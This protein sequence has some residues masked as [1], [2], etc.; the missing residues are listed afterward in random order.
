MMI[1]TL[2]DIAQFFWLSRVKKF[3]NLSILSNNLGRLL[4]LWTEQNLENTP[5]RE[6][7]WPKYENRTLC[8]TTGFYEVKRTRPGQFYDLLEIAMSFSWMFTASH[9]SLEK[10]V[11]FVIAASNRHM[12]YDFRRVEASAPHVAFEALKRAILLWNSPSIIDWSV[13]KLPRN[14]GL[15]FAFSES[16]TWEKRR[17]SFLTLHVSPNK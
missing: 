10:S 11:S 1:I 14:T 2:I 6:S 5:I 3:S 9:A 12:R 7:V 16:L 13:E 17:S 15:K 8:T 4:R